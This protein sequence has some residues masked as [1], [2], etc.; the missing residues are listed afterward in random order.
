MIETVPY[1]SA[2]QGAFPSLYAATENL[3]GGSYIGP[4]GEREING[5]PAPAAIEP[6]ALD[7]E[8]GTLL[9]EYAEKETGVRF[10]F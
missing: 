6:Y 8:I 9:W 10:P 1:M 4:D 2:N 7:A 5:Y 3:D